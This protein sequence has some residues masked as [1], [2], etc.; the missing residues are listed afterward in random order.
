MSWVDK[1]PMNPKIESIL[2][3]RLFWISIP[4]ILTAI[5]MVY[6]EFGMFVLIYLLFFIPNALGDLLVPSFISE[7]I[8]SLVGKIIWIISLFIEYFLFFIFL[9]RIKGL[10]KESLLIYSAIIFLILFLLG[11]TYL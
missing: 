7:A 8:P 10:S 11:L 5:A 3:S 9:F 2:R 1:I 6:D 4:F